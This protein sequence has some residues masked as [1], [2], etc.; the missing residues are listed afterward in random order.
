[1]LARA[2][3]PDG[4]THTAKRMYDNGIWDLPVDLRHLEQQ[5]DD[6]LMSV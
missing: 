4:A 6:F 1:M 3:D 2:V 5:L